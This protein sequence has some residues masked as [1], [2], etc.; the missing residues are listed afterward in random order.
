MEEGTSDKV[1]AK[2]ADRVSLSARSHASPSWS[3]DEDSP[4]VLPV[5][6]S[7]KVT[8]DVEAVPMALT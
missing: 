4:E 7:H 2:V 3:S 5:R 8:A 6:P 1:G